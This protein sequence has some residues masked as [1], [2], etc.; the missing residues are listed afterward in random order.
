[1]FPMRF[2][3]FDNMKLLQCFAIKDN[4]LFQ[5]LVLSAIEGYCKYFSLKIQKLKLKFTKDFRKILEKYH[6]DGTETKTFTEIFHRY[7]KNL[8]KCRTLIFSN[9]FSGLDTCIFT[10]NE[11][12]Q[13]FSRI[14]QI[15]FLFLYFLNLETDIFKENFRRCFCLY[16]RVFQKENII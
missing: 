10:K 1:M 6:C 16:F 4:S 14:L 13:V 3:H 12:P 9:F 8:L 7:C 5:F 15:R 2:W 11:L